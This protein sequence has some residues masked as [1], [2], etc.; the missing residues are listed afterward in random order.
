VVVEE[1]SLSSFAG[2]VVLIDA[3]CVLCNRF[4]RFVLQHDAKGIFH[5]AAQDSAWARRHGVVPAAGQSATDSILFCE[6]GEIFEAD[7]AVLRI[8]ARLAFPWR[9]AVAGRL[10]PAFI[11]RKFYHFVARNRYRWFGRVESCGLLTPEEMS[12]FLPDGSL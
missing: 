4:A 7:E 12:R 2:P 5:F 6:N 9:L 8:M 11:R 3:R 1:K 10:M